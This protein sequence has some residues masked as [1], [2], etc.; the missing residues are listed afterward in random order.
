MN[1]TSALQHQGWSIRRW[2]RNG[3]HGWRAHQ[4]EIEADQKLKLWLGHRRGRYARW[5]LPGVPQGPAGLPQSL[6][7]FLRHAQEYYSAELA[8][9]GYRY[10]FGRHCDFGELAFS[11]SLGAR[12]RNFKACLLSID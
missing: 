11:S 4:G 7:L 12:L 1:R 2:G 8:A 3:G 9:C 5:S 10:R 6:W